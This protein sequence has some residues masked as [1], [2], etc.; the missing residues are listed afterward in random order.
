MGRVDALYGLASLA[1]WTNTDE[2]S[3]LCK[4]AVAMTLKD[5]SHPTNQSTIDSLPQLHSVIAKSLAR[6]L[7]PLECSENNPDA[8]RSRLG[9][10]L[11]DVAR[12]RPVNPFSERA[13]ESK[14]PPGK[15]S[16]CRL[17]TQELVELLKMPTCF[18]ECR[19]VV[20]DHLGNIHGQRF[21]NH[22]SFVRFARDK[23][24]DID[25]TTPPRRHNREETVKRMLAI[26]DGKS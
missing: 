6:E 22:W 10:I 15:P 13:Q 21:T 20:L 16:P 17:T 14:Q 11:T 5:S 3:R 24:L 8:S 12:P 23:G 4:Q 9:N 1:S 25:L 19:R 2:A 18:G 26:L 7:A